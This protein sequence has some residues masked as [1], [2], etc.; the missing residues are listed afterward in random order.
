MTGVWTVKIVLEWDN[1]RRAEV[2]TL[3]IESTEKCTKFK[4]K[5]RVSGVRIGWEFIRMGFRIMFPGRKLVT[6]NE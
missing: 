1:G 5:V 6:R 4:S 2:G 3:H